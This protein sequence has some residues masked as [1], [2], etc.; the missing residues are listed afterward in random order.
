[1][2][3]GRWPAAAHVVVIANTA[4]A[5]VPRSHSSPYSHST[6]AGRATVAVMAHKAAALSE[7]SCACFHCW[8]ARSCSGAAKPSSSP[9]ARACQLARRLAAAAVAAPP[10]LAPL[11]P[12]PGCP[13]GCSALAG[14][15]GDGV[16]AG[17]PATLPVSAAGGQ[18]LTLMTAPMQAAVG[19]AGGLSCMPPL[20]C[21]SDTP[22]T[23]QDG[24][25]A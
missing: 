8:Y 17:Q 7:A 3:A 24:G 1:M 21:P 5:L 14:G 13:R 6:Q 19:V 10:A 20:V 23:V 2:A 18:L 22:A 9:A 12:G 15:P 25:W 16:P 4:S 11:L